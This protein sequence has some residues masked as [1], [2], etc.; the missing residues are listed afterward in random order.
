MADSS[1]PSDYVPGLADPFRRLVEGVR[2][3]AIFL[4]DPTGHILSWNTGA[5]RLK[6][7]KAAEIIGRHLSTFYTEEA[8]GRKWPEQELAMAKEKGHFEDEGPR[9]RK[10]GSTFWANVV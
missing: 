4:L 6:G 3:Y 5:E 9:V 2:D 1:R 10:D 8:R 7:Y